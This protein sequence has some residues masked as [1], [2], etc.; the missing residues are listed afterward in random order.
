MN[1]VPSFT[2]TGVHRS[3]PTLGVFSVSKEILK[4]LLKSSISPDILFTAI[5]YNYKPN[6]IF[7]RIL[8]VMFD[9]T[10]PTSS[11]VEEVCKDLNVEE[12]PGSLLCNVHPLMMFDWKIKELCQKLHDCVG[13]ENLADCFLVMLTFEEN[14]FLISGYQILFAKISLKNHQFECL[15]DC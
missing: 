12:V 9:S 7:K 4:D 3:L 13:G 2:V 11:M 8:F 14:L 10:A 5:N 15:R 1:V 6:K